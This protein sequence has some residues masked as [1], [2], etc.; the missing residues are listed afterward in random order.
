MSVDE[1]EKS[2]AMRWFKLRMALRLLK[3]DVFYAAVGEPRG[4]ELVLTRYVSVYGTRRTALGFLAAVHEDVARTADDY[5]EA[6]LLLEKNR[7]AER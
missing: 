5:D 7:G 3:S 6:T 2:G 4:D 1:A